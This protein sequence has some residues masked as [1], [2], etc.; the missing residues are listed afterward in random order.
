MYYLYVN[1]PVLPAPLA[2]ASVAEIQQGGGGNRPLCARRMGSVAEECEMTVRQANWCQCSR[3][4]SGRR[5]KASQ[6]LHPESWAAIREDGGQALTGA[7]AGRAIEHRKGRKFGM[8]RLLS[9][10]KA[11][12]DSPIWRGPDNCWHSARC[13]NHAYRTWTQ[14]KPATWSK[15]VNPVRTG[16]R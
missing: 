5:E 11:A 2:G 12:S 1:P 16:R 14:R 4:K 15:P 3:W 9:W 10:P 7:R 6:H 13:C 8:P